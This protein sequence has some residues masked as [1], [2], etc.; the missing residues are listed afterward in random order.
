[1]YIINPVDK[2][3]LSL[4]TSHRRSTTLSLET[5]PSIHLHMS[6]VAGLARTLERILLSVR[7]RNPS[8]VDRDEIQEKQKT[9]WCHAKLYRSQLT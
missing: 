7:I 8:P 5:Y 3:K 2:T 4:Y 1:M 9:K 6:P